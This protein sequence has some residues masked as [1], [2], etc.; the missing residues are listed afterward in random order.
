MRYRPH[1]HELNAHQD[2]PRKRLLW[3]A[4]FIAVG[5]VFLLDRLDVLDL[6]QYLGPQSRWWHFLPLLVA[7][8]GVIS[9]VSAQSVRRV[10]KGLGDIVLGVW[11][12]VCLEQLWG[13]TFANSWPILLIAF[14]VQM[15]VRGWLG[16][17]RTASNE[18][19]Q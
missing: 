8:G 19:V 5:T 18:V 6:T 10:L 7:L 14:G 15:L 1:R 11:V 9:V 12:F 2:N 17:S 4:T 13:L 16:N 3:G